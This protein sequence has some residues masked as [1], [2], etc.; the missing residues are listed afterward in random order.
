M[1]ELPEYIEEN[2]ASVRQL[3]LAPGDFTEV[4]SL[5]KGTLFAQDALEPKISKVNL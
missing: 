1:F 3:R 5:K 4:S 2:C